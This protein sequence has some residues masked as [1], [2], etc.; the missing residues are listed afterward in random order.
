MCTC[1]YRP[2]LALKALKT[3][4]VG[5]GQ[6]HSTLDNLIRRVIYIRKLDSHDWIRSDIGSSRCRTCDRLPPPPDWN[7]AY[8]S[9]VCVNKRNLTITHHVR[10]HVRSNQVTQHK[11][12]Q[13][14]LRNENERYEIQF[15]HQNERLKFETCDHKTMKITPAVKVRNSPGTFQNEPEFMSWILSFEWHF[16]YTRRLGQGITSG[17]ET[18]SKV[19]RLGLA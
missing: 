2:C 3:W 12:Q 11:M 13:A 1:S 17:I 4:L 5:F 10:T 19:S 16:W 9:N 18:L 6:W 8:K 14:W 15:D 7:P